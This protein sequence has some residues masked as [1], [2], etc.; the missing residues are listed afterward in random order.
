MGEVAEFDSPAALLA[1]EGSLFREMCMQSADWE[2]I[3]KS[4]R[5]AM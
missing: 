2:E 1:R 5:L 4:A 3:H